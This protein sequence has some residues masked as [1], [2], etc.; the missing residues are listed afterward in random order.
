VIEG[1]DWL[2]YNIFV[3]KTPRQNPT[4]QWT[5]TKTMKDRNAKQ[6]MLRGV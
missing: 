3:G 6:V 5:D 1:F 2:K 4:E